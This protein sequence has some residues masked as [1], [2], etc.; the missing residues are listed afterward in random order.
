MSKY[1]AGFGSER[2]AERRHKT[3]NA[4]RQATLPNVELR[5]AVRLVSPRGALP[6]GL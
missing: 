6:V 1:D 4:K 2:R 3:A 5:R